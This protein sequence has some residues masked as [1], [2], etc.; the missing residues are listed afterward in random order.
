[1]RQ[2]PNRRSVN[3][4][5][6][7]NFVEAEFRCKQTGRCD[8]DPYFMDRLQALRTDYGRPMI[9]TSG[10]RHVTHPVEM[11]K[12]RPGSHTFGRAADILVSHADALHLVEL[13]IKHG[14]TGFGIQQKAGSTRFIHLDDMEP[15]TTRPR[16]TIWSY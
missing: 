16:P 1:M 12:A 14:F 11:Q 3:W 13:A 7:R 2:P 5:D 9:I 10:Y 4:S 15:S 6:Y 8:M